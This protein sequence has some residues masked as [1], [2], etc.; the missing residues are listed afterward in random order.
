MKT[1]ILLAFFLLL[2]I[3]LSGQI[4]LPYTAHFD[5]QTDQNSWKQYKLGQE[6]GLSDWE[7]EKNKSSCR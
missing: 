2:S 4:A 3:F 6:T 1:P 7:F 5:T